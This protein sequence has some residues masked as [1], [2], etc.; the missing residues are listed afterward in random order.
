MNFRFKNSPLANRHQGLYFIG[1]IDPHLSAALQVTQK[2]LAGVCGRNPAG[3]PYRVCRDLLTE[4][5]PKKSFYTLRKH[6]RPF[7][8]AK[9]GDMLTHRF[10]VVISMS[11]FL[12]APHLA[13]DC[14]LFGLF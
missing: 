7:D 4:Y 14:N 3:E 8:E 5:R 11:G 2:T 12:R 9:R 1:G 13:E 6:K 10:K